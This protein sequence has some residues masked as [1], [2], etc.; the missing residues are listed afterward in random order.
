MGNVYFKMKQIDLA[1]EN[2]NEAYRIFNSIIPCNYSSRA[3]TLA[4]IGVC[5]KCLGNHDLALDTYNQVLN[6]RKEKTFLS[7]H[8]PSIAKIYN[9]IGNVY[10][11]I[12]KHDEA[13]SNYKESLKIYKETL[14]SNHF[15]IAN[16]LFNMDIIN[17]N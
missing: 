16:V 6:M 17:K 8:H 4:N 12:G 1:L 9:N 13:L 7:M 10:R 11:Q 2:Y 3:D 15:S 14:P 5:Y